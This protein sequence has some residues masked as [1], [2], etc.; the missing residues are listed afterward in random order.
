VE[1]LQLGLTCDVIENED[2]DG[3]VD[4][5]MVTVIVDDGTGNTAS[6]VV[7]NAQ[8]AVNTVRAAGI[9]VGVYAAGTVP[10][11]VA[12]TISVATGYVTSNIV[13]LV[14]AAI[15]EYINTSALGA[16]LSYTYISYLAYG[17][18]GVA[19]VSAITING[20]TADIDPGL[21]KIIK[22]SN[23]SVAS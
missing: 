16:S 19:N 13:G 23:V 14:S 9:R 3:T 4:L 5:G 15:S 20:G 11:E 22:C 18:T 1:S 21:R 10:V 12:L 8:T 7:Q 17:V 2:Y 6:T